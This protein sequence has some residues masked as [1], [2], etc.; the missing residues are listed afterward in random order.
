MTS[1]ST[2]ATPST[3]T[4]SAAPRSSRQGHPLRRLRHLRRRLGHRA[5]LLHD[6]RRPEGGRGSPRSDLRGAGAG[7]GRHRRARRAATN[8]PARRARLHPRRPVRRRPLRQDG[9]Q[10]HRVR[11][12]AGLRRGLR[13]PAQQGLGT[14][15]RTSASRSNLPDIAEV[16]RRGSVISSWLLD[17][18]AAALLKDPQLETYSGYVQDSGEGRWTVEAAVEE[19]VPA[20]VLTSA[21]YARFRSRQAHTFSEK[22]LSAMRFRLR[23]TRRG[24]LVLF[25][26]TGD[27]AHKMIFPALYA[28]TKRGALK[29]PVI[30]VASSK[31]SL[32]QLR[33]RA[34]DSIR[35]AAGSMT[36]RAASSALA[37]SLR[38][39]RLQR[40]EY[41]QVAQAG[42]GRC[43]TS[44]ILSSHSARAVRD[45]HHRAR[46]RRFGRRR[47]RYRREAIR[48]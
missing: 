8:D 42:T 3:R 35:P 38:R 40:P 48:P 46:C 37:A 15:P 12:D 36:A 31:W 9:P 16:W 34:T 21:L 5:R 14:C 33:S 44:C 4:I 13:H 25:G 6:D 43:P 47:A 22:M 28:L 11:P 32:A 39:G 41:V 19:A 1:S 26:V 30:G 18:S 17:L 23:R 29:V 45:R 10:R 2:A 24:A 7:T 20:E 27:L